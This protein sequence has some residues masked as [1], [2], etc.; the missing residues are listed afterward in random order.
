MGVFLEVSIIFFAD[1]FGIWN[2]VVRNYDVN[3]NQNCH[4]G[5]KN[6]LQRRKKDRNFHSGPGPRGMNTAMTTTRKTT[7]TM[8]LTTTTTVTLMVIIIK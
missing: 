3:K 7:T 8:P 1:S 5:Y 2:D 4:G 6:L